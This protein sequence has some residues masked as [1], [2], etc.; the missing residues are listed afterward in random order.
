MY[1][2]LMY[3]HNTCNIDVYIYLHIYGSLFVNK[4]TEG[5]DKNL[6]PNYYG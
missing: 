2:Y 3:C 5:Q 4:G 1:V 6:F